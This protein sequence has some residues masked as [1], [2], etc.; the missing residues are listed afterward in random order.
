MEQ[1]EAA[2]YPFFKDFEF[3]QY[4]HEDEGIG[5]LLIPKEGIYFPKRFFYPEL[6]FAQYLQDTFRYANHESTVGGLLSRL[7][8]D[9]ENIFLDKISNVIDSFGINIDTF[10]EH[11]HPQTFCVYYILGNIRKTA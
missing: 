8:E 2:N 7:D 4:I 6:S 10:F 11:A 1:K 9:N 3:N 5:M